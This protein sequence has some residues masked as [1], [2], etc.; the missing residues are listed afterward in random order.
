MK[1]I[2]SVLLVM[3]MLVSGM[4]TVLAEDISFSDL[5]A[6]HWAYSAVMQLVADGTVNGM[7]DGTY[8]PGKLVT[9]AEFA[10]MIGKT[11]VR[12]E[13]DF[14]DLTTGH[15]S[16][17]YVMWS[18]IRGD[19]D[20]KFRPDEPMLRDD[21]IYALWGR[22]GSPSDVKAPSV[23]T[24]QSRFK[25][26][27]AWAYSYGLMIGN[28]GIDLRL[29]EGI[30]RAEV[31]SLIVRSRNLPVSPVTD[32]A[33][34]ANEDVLKAVYE[35]CGIFEKDYSGFETMTY[36][37]LAHAVLKLASE[38]S[39]LTYY[40]YDAKEP[41]E[42]KYSKDL[43]VMGEF[44]IG[45]NKVTP[46][47]IDKPVTNL[48]ML[49]MLTFGIIRKSNEIVSYN[50]VIGKYDDAKNI[51]NPSMVSNISFAHNNGVQL[52]ANNL[53]K[54]NDIANI[55]T[56]AA[57]VLQLDN[58]IGTMSYYDIY[59]ETLEA[60]DISISRDVSLYPANSSS[61]RAV[62]E[63]VPSAVYTVPFLNVTSIDGN[64]GSNPVKSFDFARSM[65]GLF[66][67]L[68]SVETLKIKNDKGI[69][70]KV[71]FYPQ[72]VCDNKSGFTARLKIRVVSTGGK[73]VAY[74]D[75]FNLAAGADGSTV[76][77]DGLTFYADAHMP[78]ELGSDPN[79][80]MK[81]GNIICTE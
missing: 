38:E 17:E 46:E 80:A 60:H 14:A 18:G 41:F 67:K 3:T 59:G 4:L 78:Y 55:R 52:Y 11:D 21:V 66:A 42:H 72:F 56:I 32:F 2:V 63:G 70:L 29:D 1:R 65:H 75:V 45:K 35:G 48:D 54:P 15:W 31:A 25:S 77:S 23:V 33:L 57:T 13:S 74:G 20:N 69:D 24:E 62:L 76:L 68:I 73:T 58:I 64:N 27:A 44:C 9:R 49:A 37:E 36:G 16:Y 8:A 28:D 39:E 12:F 40:G 79:A 22:N 19:A 43:Y 34:I 10:K 50:T 7:G 6:D 30:S 61:F 5:S 81:F 47:I 51:E 26:A 53:I 71:T